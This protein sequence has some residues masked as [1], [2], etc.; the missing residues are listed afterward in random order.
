MQPRATSNNKTGRD[1]RVARNLSEMVEENIYE[2]IQECQ[3]TVGSIEVSVI[4][5]IA[6]LWYFH[7]YNSLHVFF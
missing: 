5:L 3:L 1:S 2:S 4:S 7:N 6:K